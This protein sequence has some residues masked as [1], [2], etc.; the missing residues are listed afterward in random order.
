MQRHD[1]IWPE[2]AAEL[3]TAGVSDYSIF[4]D[5]ETLILFAVQKL[6]DKN[7]AAELPN[8][9]VVRKWW[10]YMAPLMETHPDNSPVAKPLKEVFHLD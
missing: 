5:E 2:L 3:K 4:L 10:D 1:E 7:S 9:S 8:S 6:S